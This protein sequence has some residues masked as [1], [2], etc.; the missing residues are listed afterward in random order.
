MVLHKPSRF[1]AELPDPVA[2][3][4]G[5][6]TGLYEPWGLE[7]VAPDAL[8]AADVPPSQRI[9]SSAGGRDAADDDGDGASDARFRLES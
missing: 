7:L 3:P 1:V 5:T 4:D 9:P 6:T 8:P 2:D